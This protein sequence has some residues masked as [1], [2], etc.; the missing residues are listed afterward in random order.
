MNK[1]ALA[2]SLA[3][4][5]TA[6]IAIVLIIAAMIYFPIITAYTICGVVSVMAFIAVTLII[7]QFITTEFDIL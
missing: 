4:T 7:Y 2:I 3:I 5:T 1:K 6:T